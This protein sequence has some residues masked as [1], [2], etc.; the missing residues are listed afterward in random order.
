MRAFLI[1]QRNII[2]HA[3]IMHRCVRPAAGAC[4]TKAV[5]IRLLALQTTQKG[6]P[7]SQMQNISPSSKANCRNIPMR[8]F[9]MRFS[10]NIKKH[11]TN[12]GGKHKLRKMAFSD[13]KM[14]KVK[15]IKPLF[16]L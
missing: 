15:I 12:N 4:L 3:L 16:F 10:A 1:L 2:F 8:I 6:A 13:K 7:A 11:S 5:I 9:T 14:G